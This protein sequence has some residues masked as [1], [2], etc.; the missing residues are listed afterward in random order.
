MRFSLPSTNIIIQTLFLLTRVNKLSYVVGFNA[1]L[2]T[3]SRTFGKRSLESGN[4]F[5]I[6]GRRMTATTSETETVTNSKSSDVLS[7]LREKL[8]ALNLD[9]YL[10]P[11]D[12]PH[13]SEYVSMS[14][15]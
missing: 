11:S 15:S 14:K 1:I 13:L 2:S 5:S 9:A 10:I 4:I 6:I 3:S 7:T 8:E 12:D